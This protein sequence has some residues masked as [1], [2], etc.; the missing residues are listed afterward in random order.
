[1]LIVSGCLAGLNCRYDGKSKTNARILKMLAEGRIL[2]LCPEQLG[3][4]A[5][6]RSPVDIISGA[7]VLRGKERIIDEEG[8][9]VTANFL[10]GARELLKIAR[11]VNP[12]LIILKSRSP[13]CGAHGVTT[14]LLKK[15]GFKVITDE[16]WEE[17]DERS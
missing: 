13:S 17:L 7:D 10:H 11:M 5:T 15:Q 3:G 6:P 16:E 2:P 12:G 4:L 14:A 1:M 8:Q 9:D